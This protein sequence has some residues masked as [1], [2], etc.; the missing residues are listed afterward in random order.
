M[1]AETSARSIPTCTAPKL[2]PPA[3]THAVRA[4][5]MRAPVFTCDHTRK[6]C[7]R[8]LRRRAEFVPARSSGTP[9]VRKVF[10]DLVTLAAIVVPVQLVTRLAARHL[11][12][13]IAERLVPRQAAAAKPLLFAVNH[14]AAGFHRGAPYDPCHGLRS[15]LSCDP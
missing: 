4:S 12:R 3:R 7:E 5:D 8:S 1:P 9:N 10:C 11:V 2:P 15:L 6:P 13:A 14:D